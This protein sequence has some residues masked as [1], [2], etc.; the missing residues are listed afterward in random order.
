MEGRTGVEVFCL[1]LSSSTM[2]PAS[3]IGPITSPWRVLVTR[4]FRSRGEIEESVSSDWRLEMRF[5]P[6][7]VYFLSFFLF[8]LS[9]SLNFST[10]NRSTKN[11]S[12]CREQLCNVVTS[13]Q[14]RVVKRILLRNLCLLEITSSDLR[15]CSSIDHGVSNPSNLPRII[16]G[17][18]ILILQ[19]ILSK[20]RK[21]KKKTLVQQTDLIQ[22]VV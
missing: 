12:N 1:C 5:A 2:G 14:F 10:E 21:K 18:K 4:P 8:F 6:T 7:F 11:C 19:P 3:P 22:I 15:V 9:R 17:E 13:I 16:R 20:Q